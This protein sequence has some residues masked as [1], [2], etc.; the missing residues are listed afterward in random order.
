MELFIMGG[1]IFTH[2][3]DYH[4]EKLQSQSI[5]STFERLRLCAYR[6]NRNP[7]IVSLLEGSLFI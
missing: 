4:C 5:L 6:I 1:L 7:N 3:Y 2:F